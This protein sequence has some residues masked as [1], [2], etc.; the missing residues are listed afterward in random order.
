MG[1]YDRRFQILQDYGIPTVWIGKKIEGINAPN[2]TSDNVLGGYRAAMHLIQTGC[3]RLCFMAARTDSYTAIEDRFAGFKNAL[4][5]TGLPLIDDLVILERLDYE[6]SYEKTGAILSCET[7]PDGIFAAN[8]AVAAGVIR[9]LTRESISVPGEVSVIGY[10][11]TDLSRMITPQISSVKNPVE[12]MGVQAVKTLLNMI[13]TQK[14]VA[15]EKVFE[16]TLY[17]R[18]TTRPL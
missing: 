11:D 2:I 5:E 12:E 16:P 7:K 3:R 4:L 9:R 1:T 14:A 10:D 17:L 6:E 18:E 15:L 13:Y 8:D